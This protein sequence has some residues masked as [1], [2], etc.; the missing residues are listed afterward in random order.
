MQLAVAD[1]AL[2]TF[3]YDANGNLL[4]ASQP[5]GIVTMTYDVENRLVLYQYGRTAA[6]YTYSGDGQKRMEMVDG[7]ATTIVWDAQDYLQG[8]S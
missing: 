6:T 5:S 7:V 8:R 2:T 1:S 4:L 3:G